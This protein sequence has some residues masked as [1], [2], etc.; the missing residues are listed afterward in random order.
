MGVAH[1]KVQ[2]DGTLLP[3][4]GRH[5]YVNINLFEFMRPFWSSPD[6]FATPITQR[7]RVATSV[8]APPS[9]LGLLYW[10]MLGLNEPDWALL[11]LTEPYWA[12]LGLIGPYCVLLAYCAL[13]LHLYTN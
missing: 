1:R 4:I 3:A 2:Q 13:L 9:Q 6:L 5:H 12:L 8:G 10:A 7:G 11:G